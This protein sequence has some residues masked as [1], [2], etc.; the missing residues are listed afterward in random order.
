MTAL[1]TALLALAVLWPA[2]TLSAFDGV[3]L[4]GA[5]EAV[6]IGVIFP[7]LWWLHRSFLR[8]RA[9][10][11][12]I[13]ALL[14]VRVVDWTALPQHGLCLSASTA[15]P[16][17]GTITT[18]PI[19]E[20]TGALRSWDVRADWRAASPRCTAIV[21]R[22]YTATA[23]FPAAWRNLIA[24]IRPD[25][26]IDLRV[27]GL[28]NAT[29][30]GT[31]T[32]DAARAMTIDG[33]IDE[34]PVRANAGRQ[35]T[36]PMSAGVHP[37]ALHAI[38]GD[39]EWTLR[40]LWD[41]R[42]AWKAVRFTIAP[43]NT[44]D[45]IVS[46]MLAALSTLFVVA[47]AGGWTWS[48]AAAARWSPVTITWTLALTVTFAICGATGRFDRV[49][50]LALL[51]AAWLPV[52]A[53]ER[54]VR[55]A[56]MLIGVPWLSLFVARSWPLIGRVT[57]FSAGD[58]W[59][60]YQAAA[61]RIVMNG[62]WIQGGTPTF[63]FQP[64]YRWIVGLLHLLFGDSSVG[65]TYLDAFCLL[66]AAL[67][68]VAAVRRAFGYRWGVIAGA[69]TLST[70]TV[71][72]IWYLIG[73][74]LS[75]IAGLGFMVAAAAL[76]VG[77]RRGS[78]GSA[79]AAG[80]C[81]TMMFYT[82]LNH[83]LVTAFLLAWMLPLRTA[84]NWRDVVRALARVPAAPVATY[85]AVV[86]VGVLLFAARTWWYAGHFSILY[87]TSF[88][89]QQTGFQPSKMVE[90]V[91]SQLSMREPPALDPRSVLV[92][93]GAVIAALAA[94]Q[95]PGASAIPAVLAIMTVG[96]IAGSFVAHTHDY[97]GRM[98]VHV[99]PFAVAMT[100]CVAARVSAARGWRD[101]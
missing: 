46:P 97:P 60:M 87:G 61:Y 71:S 1:W 10:H 16:F 2:H 100:T 7:A 75:E 17:D 70:F 13:V 55:G 93:V 67:L 80:L 66:A 89:A 19:E 6:V 44:F 54:R 74:S 95:V 86:A 15:A 28:L 8:Q 59:Q 35:I 58:D 96:T 92:A 81:A 85:A 41:G 72:A 26:R 79:A 36:M 21:D 29:D 37:I 11:V 98:S 40:P 42:D 48:C 14:L 90:A 101:R 83:L 39:G 30:G 82:R 49:A 38:L 4:S 34:A 32:I 77:A 69:L 91:A 56:F 78:I 99:V 53:R 65:D 76:L 20:P 57:M 33:T 52:A 25:A 9:A 47:L 43:S 84:T 24:A 50:A 27:S 18:I 5:P 94:C 22:A 31:F 64:L 62:Y 12:L 88:G 63:L 51:A 23:E 3:P 73:R 45:R 68:V